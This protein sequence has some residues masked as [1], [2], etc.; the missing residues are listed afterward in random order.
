MHSRRIT[1]P[2][3]LVSSTHLVAAETSCRQV[4]LRSIHFKQKRIPPLSTLKPPCRATVSLKATCPGLMIGRRGFRGVGN[5]CFSFPK[6][7]CLSYELGTQNLLKRQHFGSR[8]PSPT[9]RW[10][11]VKGVEP[12]EACQ[13]N[14][15]ADKPSTSKQCFNPRAR[16]RAT[17]EVSII[18]TETHMAPPEAD[19]SCQEV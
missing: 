17:R 10:S 5:A 15:Q 1:T 2:E 18:P 12:D 4:L 11:T 6:P 16:S 3:P 9:A 13:Q 8:F 7:I 19:H 14:I